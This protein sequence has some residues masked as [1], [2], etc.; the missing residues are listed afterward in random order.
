MRAQARVARGPAPL[1]VVRGPSFTAAGV[2]AMAALLRVRACMRLQKEDKKKDD[3]HHDHDHDDHH[4][5]VRAAAGDPPLPPPPSAPR[6]SKRN[7]RP[8]LPPRIV[9]C[10]SAPACGV[11]IAAPA[12]L[13]CSCRRVPRPA[14]SPRRARHCAAHRVPTFSLTD[15]HTVPRRNCPQPKA[16]KKDDHHHDHDDDHHHDSHKEVRRA[17]PSSLRRPTHHVPEGLGSHASSTCLPRRLP[18]P[19]DK[20]KA[21]SKAA[22]PPKEVLDA[23]KASPR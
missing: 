3:H 13:D 17:R 8:P 9:A 20:K 14:P 18:T 6:T 23:M 16:K 11:C 19:Q 22:P 2:A 12:C 10:G 5:E 21:E 7:A 1:R 15:C 4:H